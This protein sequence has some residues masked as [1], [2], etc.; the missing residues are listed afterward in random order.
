MPTNIGWVAINKIALF[1]CLQG[2]LKILTNKIPLIIFYKKSRLFDLISNFRYVGLR[3][4][5]WFDEW[6]FFNK[7]SIVLPVYI[8]P[9][10]YRKQDLAPFSR[11][12][13]ERLLALLRAW[14]LSA[15]L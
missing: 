3:K 15:S 1:G 14:T 10:T 11:L 13:R 9:D 5:F 4:S 2:C 6:V 12:W 7:F 8:S